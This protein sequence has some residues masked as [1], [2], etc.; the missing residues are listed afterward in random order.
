M[1]RTR[2]TEG[3]I[4]LTRWPRESGTSVAENVRKPGVS[5]QTLPPRFK[6][7]NVTEALRPDGVSKARTSVFSA[8]INAPIH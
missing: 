2:N 8:R 7:A 3:Q 6:S 5:E 1:K 4:T